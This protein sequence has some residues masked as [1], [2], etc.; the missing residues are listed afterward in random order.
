MVDNSFLKSDELL[1][2]F[3]GVC[4]LCHRSVQFILARDKTARFKFASLQSQFA[5]QQLDLYQINP[6]TTDSIVLIYQQKAYIYSSAALRIGWHLG[7]LY[8][9]AA[10]AWLIPYFIRDWGYK[11]IAANRYKYWGKQNSCWLPKPEWAGRFLG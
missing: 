4:N 8:K 3:D 11:L 2:L 10:L 9:M 6:K 7:G 1:V 5:Q